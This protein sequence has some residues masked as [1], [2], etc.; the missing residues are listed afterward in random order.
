MDEEHADATETAQ[1]DTIRL[2]T[3]TEAMD[4]YADCLAPFFDDRAEQ[5]R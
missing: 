5:P 2:L 3:F 4:H 1:P